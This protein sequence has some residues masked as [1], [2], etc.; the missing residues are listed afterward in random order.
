[1]PTLGTK[2][3]CSASASASLAKFLAASTRFRAPR[4]GT[5]Q[6]GRRPVGPCFAAFPT[7]SSSFQTTARFRCSRFSTWR[8]IPPSGRSAWTVTSNY[9]MQ[10]SSLVGTPIAGT[11]AGMDRLRSASGAPTAS[12]R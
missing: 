10:R 7:V 11:G 2:L 8:A 12:R 6:C 1:M 3:N 5:S 4:S 9:A